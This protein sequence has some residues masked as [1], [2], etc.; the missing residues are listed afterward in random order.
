MAMTIDQFDAQGWTSGMI[1]S[2][3]VFVVLTT[4]GRTIELV[5]V[6]NTTP[7]TGDK[8]DSDNF[9]TKRRFAK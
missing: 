3:S 6:A 7:N 4:N 8:H 5:S 1:F 2:E 9:E